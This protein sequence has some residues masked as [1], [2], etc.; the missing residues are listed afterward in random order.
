[1]HIDFGY[2]FEQAKVSRQPIQVQFVSLSR[3][4]PDLTLSRLQKLLPTPETVPFRL[5][6][7]MMDGMG[8]C[9]TEGAFVSAAEDTMRLLRRNKR[10]LMTIL[11]AVLSDPLYKWTMDPVEAKRQQQADN[12]VEELNGILGQGPTASKD[13]EANEEKNKSGAAAIAKIQEKLQGYEDSTS[14]QQQ[15]VESQ[16]AFLLDAARDPENLCRLFAGW[17]AWV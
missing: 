12:E 15:G 17:M 14:G 6:R 7:N 4:V 10:G 2:V 8:P 9:G 3:F 1:M 5:T 13:A 11:S 16:V